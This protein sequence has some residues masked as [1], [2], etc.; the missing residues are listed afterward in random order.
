MKENSLKIKCMEMGCM[1]GK[2][3]TNILANGKILSETEKAFLY[4]N[5]VIDIKE[6]GSMIR[7][8]DME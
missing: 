1:S 6:I 5:L 8:M 4:G 2:K 7:D 3:E